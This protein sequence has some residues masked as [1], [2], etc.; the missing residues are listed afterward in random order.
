MKCATSVLFSTPLVASAVA[1]GWVGTLTIAAGKAYKGNQPLE[2]VPNGAPSVIRQIASNLVRFPGAYQANDKGIRIDVYNMKGGYQFP[3]PPVATLVEDGSPPNSPCPHSE[4]SSS[5]H[6][7]ATSTSHTSDHMDL[8]THGAMESTTNAATAA[9]AT[10]TCK[11]KH[12]RSPEAMEVRHRRSRVRHGR[13][14]GI[15]SL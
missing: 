14:V 6:L 13:P 12:K 15:H 5:A 7:N 3:G 4:S 10:K 11:G 2:Q 1:H 8:M 9:A